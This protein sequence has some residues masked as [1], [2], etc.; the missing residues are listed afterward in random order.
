MEVEESSEVELWCLKEL[1]LADVDLWNV[2]FVAPHSFLIIVITYVLE[3]VDALSGLLDLAA[4]DLWDQLGGELG[5][6]AGGSLALDDLNHLLANGADLGRRSV[7][8]LLDLVWTTLGKGNG[9]HAEEVIIGGLNGDVGL[10]KSLPLADKGSQLVGGEVK[11][12]EVGQAVL[13][14]NL[15]DTELDL[16]ESVVLILLKI[17][18]RDLNDTALQGVVGVLETGGPV[19]KSLAD[20]S[21][22]ER[23][24]CLLYCERL[25]RSRVVKWIGRAIP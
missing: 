8:G 21:N 22:L 17:G 18:E 9:E 16:A 6:G 15:I 12:V 4:D 24:W 11:T 5:K 10:D 20:I 1:D 19:D 2:S 13:A 25:I 3:W 14:L 23:G 7:G